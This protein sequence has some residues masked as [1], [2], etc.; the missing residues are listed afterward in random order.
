M[1]EN[2]RDASACQRP[3]TDRSVCAPCYIAYWTV[4]YP[5]QAA[6]CEES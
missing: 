6:F 4:K 3:A 1:T 2:H 5:V